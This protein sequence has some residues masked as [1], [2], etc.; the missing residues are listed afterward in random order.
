[1]KD[2]S[3]IWSQQQRWQREKRGL[4]SLAD[5]GLLTHAA[6]TLEG[7]RFTLVGAR[8]RYFCVCMTR[9]MS[10]VVIRRMRGAGAWKQN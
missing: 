5:R 1:M 8:R 4:V 10:R 2:S 7:I 3:L 9:N 6:R